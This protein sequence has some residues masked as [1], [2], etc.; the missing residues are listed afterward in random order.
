MSWQL[1]RACLSLSVTSVSLCSYPLFGPVNIQQASI[2]VFS[3]T[4]LLSTSV[5]MSK[6]V[7]RST[8]H[9]PVLVLNT[10]WWLSWSRNM[11]CDWRNKDIV[12]CVRWLLFYLC[13]MKNIRLKMGSKLFNSA[14]LII[15]LWKRPVAAF[16]KVPSLSLILYDAV[17]RNK[18][19]I[20]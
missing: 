5:S 12:N 10:W 14:M 2:D 6:I 8:E 20:H 11:S 9:M 3:D 15:N 19:S 16:Q 13:H 1:S 4:P 7:Y 18:V 17:N